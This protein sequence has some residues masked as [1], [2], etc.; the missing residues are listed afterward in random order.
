MKQ[1]LFIA[2]CTLSIV[3]A[4]SAER[5]SLENPEDIKDAV[6]L[7]SVFWDLF[8]NVSDCM[9]QKGD[10]HDACVRLYPKRLHTLQTYLTQTLQKHPSW[11][12][13][14]L[15]YTYRHHGHNLNMRALAQ[16]FLDK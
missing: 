11:R 1:I 8:E 9:E 6:A 5:L 15:V 14:T 4:G 10:S 3:Y 7:D 16:H 2:I 12:G 13:K